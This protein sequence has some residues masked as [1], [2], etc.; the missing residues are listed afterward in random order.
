MDDPTIADEITTGHALQLAGD[1]AAAQAH[2][3]AIWAAAMQAGDA[4]RAC[5][6]A[7]FLA[8]AHTTAEAQRDWH[9]RALRAAEAATADGDARVLDCFPSL[10]ANLAEVALRLGEQARARGYLDQAR[11]SAA[12]LGD[13]SY[14]H[15]IGGLIDR[16]MHALSDRN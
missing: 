12:V 10:Y 13:D 5:I 7:H 6:A 16:L 1:R 3:A 4:Y 11:A 8:H 2:F 15:M 14:G 9:E